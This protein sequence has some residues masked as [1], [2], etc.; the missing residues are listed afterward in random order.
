MPGERESFDDLARQ[1]RDSFR[2]GKYM[3][4]SAREGLANIP[5]AGHRATKSHLEYLSGELEVARAEDDKDRIAQL[6]SFIKI[7]Q[8]NNQK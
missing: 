3:A 2:A 5:R 8:E 1:T 6:E 7:V 4:E